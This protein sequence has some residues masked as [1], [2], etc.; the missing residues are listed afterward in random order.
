MKQRE[1]GEE[2]KGE[3]MAVPFVVEY[4]RPKDLPRIKAIQV[5]TSSFFLKGLLSNEMDQLDKN[6][7]TIKGTQ[8]FH[9]H[10]KLIE[11]RVTFEATL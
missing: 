7:K 5:K 3:E 1:D 8:L 9:S 4:L 6:V 2:S 11:R 10:E